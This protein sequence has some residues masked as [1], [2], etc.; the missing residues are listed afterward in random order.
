MEKC[1]YSTI[2]Q[3]Q[4]SHCKPRLGMPWYN[5]NYYFCVCS[6]ICTVICLYRLF[7][8]G[9]IHLKCVYCLMRWTQNFVSKRWIPSQWVEFTKN[10][11][12]K[13]WIQ[14][15]CVH[16]R[17]S[18]TIHINQLMVQPTLINIFSLMQFCYCILSIISCI[19]HSMLSGQYTRFDQ[20]V[21]AIFEF[22]GRHTFL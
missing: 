15:G 2:F 19:P 22:L 8:D 4:E 10:F 11:Q 1:L 3:L 13:S 18:S 16:T 12:W 20:K 6:K 17:G 5:S 21:C 14:I 9:S 7:L